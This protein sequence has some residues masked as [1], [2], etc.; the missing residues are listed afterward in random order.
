MSRTKS[1]ISLRWDVPRRHV[2]SA[3]K[4]ADLVII[5]SSREASPIVVL[6]SMAAGT[7]WVSFDVGCVRENAGGTV[8][9]SVEEMVD[10]AVDLLGDKRLRQELGRLGRSRVVEKQNWANIAGE[11]EDYYREIFEN[12]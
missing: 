2:V 4:E 3:I 12:G 8:V 7:P 11:Y 9:S 5:T 10:V 1:N 6:E